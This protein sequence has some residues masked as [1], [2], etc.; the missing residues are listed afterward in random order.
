MRRTGRIL[1][2][3]NKHVTLAGA[4]AVLSRGGPNIACID[5]CRNDNCRRT[6]RSLFQVLGSI[7]T[8]GIRRSY[9]ARLARRLRGATGS[10]RC[11]GTRT[12]VRI[13]VRHL[14]DISSCLG[15][16]CRAITPPL[17]QTSGGLRDAVLPLL[18][19]RRRNKGRG[20]LLFKGHL[21]SRTLCGAS[22]AVFAEAE[23]PKRRGHLTITLLV[24]RDNSVN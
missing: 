1:S 21:S 24:S 15:G 9:R 20:G 11:N 7:T 22:K 5:R 23:L 4:G 13:A 18:G 3:R 14:A 12:N 8:R 16:R 2:R 6:T 10:V 17:L 19:R